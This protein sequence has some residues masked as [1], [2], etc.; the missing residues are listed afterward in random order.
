MKKMLMA[1]MAAA[2]AFGTWADTE[3]VGDYTWTYRINGGA[4]EI[5]KGYNS[6]A[7]S[8]S[9]TDAVTIPSTLGG[10]PV[11]SIGAYAFYY[12]DNLTSVTIPNSVTNIGASAFSRCSYLQ[13]VEIPSTVV[14]IGRSAFEDCG[15]LTDVTI[16]N[17][18]R[19]ISE[20]MFR[21]CATLMD[22][23]IP[24]SVT[25]IEA[26]AFFGCLGLTCMTIP[27]GVVTLGVDLFYGCDNLTSISIPS[28]VTD[29]PEGNPFEGVL[30]ATVSV[31]WRNPKYHMSNGQL[32]SAD[33]CLVSA[34]LVSGN[35][36]IPYDATRIGT[37]AFGHIPDL[38]SITI[39]A[40]VT[41]IEFYAF[42]TCPNLKRV[43][44][45]EP[46]VGK[47]GLQKLGNSAF[48]WCTGLTSVLL[49]STVTNID[50][51]AF[52]MCS[53]LTSIT[54]PSSVTRLGRYVF[55]EC[56]AL[57]SV[58]FEGN[59]PDVESDR[60]ASYGYSS[61]LTIYVKKGSRG[62]D[63]DPL[64]AELPSD[65]K[66][67]YLP[68]AWL[69]PSTTVDSW[70]NGWWTRYNVTTSGDATWFAT[71]GVYRSRAIHGGSSG[72][73]VT[74]EMK[75]TGEG[76]LSFDRIIYDETDSHGSGSYVSGITLMIDGE[77]SGYSI[78]GSQ[79]RWLHCDCIIQGS[80]QHTITWRWTPDFYAASALGLQNVNW[81]P[82]SE[83]T[84]PT[85]EWAT[86][87]NVNG[88]V[89]IT[90]VSPTPQFD[91]TVPS[92][93]NGRT[94]TVLG[95]RL[96]Y[97]ARLVSSVTVPEGVTQIGYSAFSGMHGLSSVSLPSTLT[98]LGQSVFS[99]CR[100]LRTIELPSG[101][102]RLPPYLFANCPSLT[103]IVFK[104]NAPT[105]VDSSAFNFSENIV[106]YVS[107]E[108]TGWG[109]DIPGTWKGVPIAYL[110]W[111]L[112]LDLTPGGNVGWAWNASDDAYRSGAILDSQSSTLTLKVQGAGLLSF[113][114]KMSSESGYDKLSV[115]GDG[116]SLASAISGEMSWSSVTKTFNSAGTHTVVWTYSKDSGVSSGSDCG[117]V[118]D[119][120]WTPYH[121][122]TFAANGGSVSP[123]SKTVA[124]DVEVGSLPI[125]TRAGHDFL[126]W[127]T[128]QT[129]G[130]RVTAS[131]VVTADVKYFAHWQI[132]T[133]QVT[134]DL[135]V[136]GSRIGGGTLSQTVT[137]QSA[138]AAPEV[139]AAT[140]WV[141]T[142]WDAPFT[143][144][145]DALTVHALYER[146]P[147]T[148]AEAAGGDLAFTT[149]GAA[150][151][152]AEWSDDA[153]D[154]LHHTRSGAVGNKQASDL[155]TTVQGAGIVSFWCR[156][157]SEADEE[158]VYDGLS[159]WVDGE[160]RTPGLIGGDIGWTNLTFEI[161]GP[162]THTLCWRYE[163]DKRDAAGYDCAWLDEVTWTPMDG[164]T[165]WLAERNLTAETRAANGRTA[166]ECYALGLDP[167]L[168]T[169]DFR[170]VSIELVDG[171]PKV[172]WEP[173]VNRWTGA[174]IP[175]VLKGAA[176][177]D[178]EWKAVEGASAAEKAAMRFFKVVVEVP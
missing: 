137:Y 171:K 35:A 74:C 55:Q 108:S 80:G 177:L 97:D 41:D 15:E 138:A 121:V 34:F 70:V 12:C 28:T 99:G 86:T 32:V 63:Y 29:I 95:D 125:P 100:S 94:V 56:S 5:Y 112:G 11:T 164:L 96:F 85:Y 26:S 47:P 161:A 123:S 60:L 69:N 140:G 65:G 110:P 106:I 76:V 160:N 40:H 163:K 133:Y 143:N 141:F 102:T 78:A 155:S 33:G 167:A 53:S 43:I 131:T 51:Y 2:V 24:S 37:Y 176:T 151:W 156:V 149:D 14:S 135:G 6:A 166:A 38:T 119:V 36:V 42:S 27:E 7:I 153:H 152:F 168:A 169:N 82:K 104:G 49:P 16:P 87:N 132:K 130:S 10:K 18:V 45:D 89:T 68:V 115:T 144:V 58:M 162:G 8:P 88:T 72:Q 129:G 73:S 126:G 98:S 81:L 61:S 148:V 57:Q 136:Q 20:R 145:T 117:W 23:T 127:Y 3:T 50:A 111:W 83:W 91:V 4:A 128:E 48:G 118:T 71:N 77:P 170:I 113:K 9:P 103:S 79:K 105:T 92:R 178:G 157:S 124:G 114:W 52:C 62:W 146:A 64:S 142:G 59:A 44:F 22:V 66:W 175:A 120:T 90:G 158:D 159:F 39:P 31:D 21:N 13:S 67:C 75:V 147:L 107:R 19:T 165:A 134:F 46:S 154:G 25:N 172:E 17:G 109:V 150:E 30:N 93:L 122:V 139:E 173:K 1:L 84:E 54:I 116:S 174:E 101:I